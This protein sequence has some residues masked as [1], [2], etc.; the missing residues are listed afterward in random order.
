MATDYANAGGTGDRTGSIWITADRGF[1]NQDAVSGWVDNVFTNA[2]NNF[3]LTGTTFQGKSITFDFRTG[4][5]VDEIRLY[6]ETGGNSQGTWDVSGSNDGENFTSIATAVAWTGT[7]TKLLT[8]TNSTSYRYYRI[9]GATGTIT[10]THWRELEFKIEQ[11][12][13]DVA[14]ST[15]YSNTGGTGDRTASITLSQTSGLFNSATLSVFVDGL[16]ANNNYVPNGTGFQGKSVTFDFGVGASKVI[17]EIRLVMAGAE[18]Q[19]TWQ[20]SASN[21]GTD[22]T[23]LGS[24][25][26]WPRIATRVISFFNLTGYRYYRMTGVSG[27]IVQNFMYEYQFRIDDGVAPPSGGSRQ[28]KKMMQRG[29]GFYSFY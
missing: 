12:A 20:V 5:I 15:S 18:E 14:S 6:V 27:T 21:N 10:Q 8:F 26:T 3:P 29:T 1:L 25:K 9:T 13:T 19:G 16:S 7:T 24:A 23:N 28:N 11:G 17:D 4:K 2:A 22:F